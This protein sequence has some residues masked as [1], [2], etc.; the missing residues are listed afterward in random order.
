MVKVGNPQQRYVTR[1]VTCRDDSVSL[2]RFG[3]LYADSTGIDYLEG[4]KKQNEDL[5]AENIRIR[6]KLEDVSSFQH[7]SNASNNAANT[8][9]AFGDYSMMGSG[10]GV[11]GESTGENDTNLDP[12]LAAA[13][14]QAQQSGTEDAKHDET[15]LDTD[16]IRDSLTQVGE[17]V[18]GME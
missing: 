12:S 8:Y 6:K 14:A 18:E 9:G 15:P 1:S 2:A 5:L 13:A 17:R 7:A 16:A 3:V 11:L 10:S 4:L